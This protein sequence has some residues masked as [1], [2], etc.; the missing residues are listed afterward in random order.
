MSNIS[1]IEQELYSKNAYEDKLTAYVADM[2]NRSYQ[3]WE[4]KLEELS[5]FRNI[6][7][8]ILQK[9]GIFYIGD[10]A[11]M[12]VPS[13]LKD[14]KNFGV[15]SPT[16]KKPIFNHRYVIPILNEIGKVTNLVGYSALADERYIY[17]TA[18]YYRRTDT[19]Y[20]LEN[21][22]LAYN[23]GYAVQVEGITDTLS[24][25]KVNILNSFGNCGTHS[26]EYIQSQLNRC[27]YGVIRIPDR[28]EAGNRA[29]KGWI[30]NK[31]ITLYPPLQFKD[32]DE[33]LRNNENIEWFM[34]YFNECVKFL[35]G[36]KHNGMACA[37]FEVT[38]M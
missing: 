9:A 33:M 6:P 11:E 27:E 10:M 20:G 24:L 36:S 12:L 17:G 35:K 13:F 15:I 19:L 37:P 7:L 31:Y 14:I 5:E 18:H 32:V 23:M 34:A 4:T 2:R 30:T 1:N 22:Q 21:L 28:D 25:R 38:I 26:S 8:E 3:I 16:N 29:K